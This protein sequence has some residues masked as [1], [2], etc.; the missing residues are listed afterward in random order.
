M[1]GERFY[2]IRPIIMVKIMFSN[3]IIFTNCKFKFGFVFFNPRTK[4]LCLAYVTYD[5]FLI[6]LIYKHVVRQFIKRIFF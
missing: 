6:N 2:V 3:A 4:T 1:N 5:T